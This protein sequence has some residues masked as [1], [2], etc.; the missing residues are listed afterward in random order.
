MYV[1][2]L[3]LVL[4]S[5]NMRSNE[6]VA[7]PSAL[8]SSMAKFA[9]PAAIATGRYM[10]MRYLPI[11]RLMSYLFSLDIFWFGGGGGGWI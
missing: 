4:W 2:P 10:Q 5:A 8:T 3:S 1:M 11:S 7:A 6:L 9:T